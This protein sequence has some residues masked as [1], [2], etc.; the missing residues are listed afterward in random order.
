MIHDNNYHDWW[1]LVFQPSHH[2]GTNILFSIYGATCGSMGTLFNL[3][4]SKTSADRQAYSCA[5]NNP[6]TVLLYWMVQ[7]I[8]TFTIRGCIGDEE[9]TQILGQDI[10]NLFVKWMNQSHFTF[11]R[12]LN[13]TMTVHFCLRNET[14]ILR[15]FWIISKPQTFIFSHIIF[16]R[17]SNMWMT[18]VMAREETIEALCIIIGLDCS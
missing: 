16:D 15:L 2:L 18:T 13:K 10:Q 9:D 5:S 1:C 6:S 12:A 7:D 3:W 8:H 14:R 17:E 11:Y 4:A